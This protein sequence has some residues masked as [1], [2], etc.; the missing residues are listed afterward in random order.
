VYVATPCTGLV[1][2]EWALARFGQISPC[3]WGLKNAMHWVPQ[4]APLGYLVADAQNIAVDCFLKENCEWLLFVEHD[5]C[6]P[7]NAF[8][9]FNQYIRR[10]TIPMVSGLYFTKSFPSEPILYRGRS[11]S[12]FT[13]WRLGDKIWVDGVPTGVLLIHRSILEAVWK[14]AEPYSIGGANVR[15]VFEQPERTWFDPQ[16]GWENGAGTSDLEFCSKL[17]VGGYLAKAGWPKFQRKPYP[18]LVDTNLFCYHIDESGRQFPSEEERA[19]W[20]PG[21]PGDGESAADI[22]RRRKPQHRRVQQYGGR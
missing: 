2:I 17:I 15:R 1:R 5:N 10:K 13:D 11:N 12:F 4:V 3:N 18:F 6:L 14:D 8:L 19:R 7:G 20:A 21:G 22:R 16:S 9:L